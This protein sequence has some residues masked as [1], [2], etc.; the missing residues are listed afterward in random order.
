MRGGFINGGEIMSFQIVIEINCGERYC[1]K[2][3][4]LI[5]DEREIYPYCSAFRE[6]VPEEQNGHHKRLHECLNAEGKIARLE[7]IEK[8]HSNEI[9]C[10]TCPLNAW[11]ACD[12]ICRSKRTLIKKIAE[13]AEENEAN[14]DAVDI[15]K[16]GM[17]KLLQNLKNLVDEVKEEKKNG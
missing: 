9:D 15:A 12:E 10:N 16:E 1:D 6:S 13:L 5:H 14:E 4:L 3:G 17:G 2:C 7:E 11:E 8:E